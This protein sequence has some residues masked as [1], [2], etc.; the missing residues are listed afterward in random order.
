MHWHH[1]LALLLAG[2][3]CIGSAAAEDDRL[4]IVAPWEINSLDPVQSGY[5]YGRMQVAETLVKSDIEGNLVPGLATDWKSEDGGK[6]WHFTLRDGVRFHDD[7]DMTTEAVVASLERTLA[8]PGALSA[9]GIKD[10]SGEGHTLT[11]TLASP[12]ASLPALLTHYSSQILAPSAYDEHG[13]V[14]ALIATGPY[15]AANLALPQRLETESFPHYWGAQPSITKASYLAAPRGETR[16]LMAQSGDADI[17]FTLDA[18]SQAR[19][20]ATSGVRLEAVPIPRTVVI[21]LNA[22]KAGFDNA[23]ARHAISQ[24]IN[25]Q[26]I[27]RGVMRVEDA[28]ASQL[29]PPGVPGWHL[30]DLAV[31]EQDLEAAEAILAKQG[32]QRGDDGILVKDGQRFSATLTTFA[33][34]PELPVI[35]TALQDQFRQLGI[36]VNVSIGNSSDIPAGHHDGSLDM[37]LLARNF[38]LV[39]D[40]LPTIM[41]DY[42]PQGGDWGAMHWSNGELSSILASLQQTDSTSSRTQLAAQAAGILHQEM[43]VIPVAWY[44]QTAA[45]NERLSGFVIDP[46]DQSYRLSELSWRK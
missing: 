42:G 18:A 19:L 43:P 23:E 8:N 24:V 32:W 2:S 38:G 39:P 22:S 14:T 34:R 44:V 15:R 21:K 13:K 28:A 36:D 20:K 6:V 40:P 27:A 31:P 25:R 41:Q 1:S 35:A 4:D 33:D 11:F 45:V 29:L 3:L 26:G 16:A 46:F 12:Y 10:I 17:A 5:V 30:D 9:A 37:G 7:S